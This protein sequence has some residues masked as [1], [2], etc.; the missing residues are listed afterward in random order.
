MTH[1]QFAILLESISFLFVTLD[2]YGKE[3]LEKF[4]S[5]LKSKL[6]NIKEDDVQSKISIF[7]L[8]THG[9]FI[10]ILL[11]LIFIFFVLIKGFP[12][13]MNPY[14]LVFAFM[15]LGFLILFFDGD[16]LISLALLIIRKYKLEGFLLYLGT[17]LFFSSKLV[18]W[19]YSN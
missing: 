9:G 6:D 19:L 17:L 16:K 15:I 18:S 7:L 13:F 4:Q 1:N 14:F 5:N 12:V 10:V 3:R 11:L 8:K 2:L